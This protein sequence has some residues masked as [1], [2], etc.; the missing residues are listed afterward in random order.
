MLSHLLSFSVFLRASHAPWPIT[1]FLP[2]SR[3]P[4]EKRSLEVK[5]VR[6]LSLRVSPFLR[7]KNRWPTDN[8]AD[9]PVTNN[10]VYIAEWLHLSNAEQKIKKNVEHLRLSDHLDKSPP[11]LLLLLGVYLSAQMWARQQH[12][13]LNKRQQSNLILHR[14]GIITLGI[15]SHI[16]LNRTSDWNL[17]ILEHYFLSET[18]VHNKSV[19]KN[20]FSS[21]LQ[22][23]SEVE[24]LAYSRKNWMAPHS[25]PSYCNGWWP[26]VNWCNAV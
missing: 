10:A 15:Q 11:S 3:I 4:R 17:I 19:V 8:L 20:A 1:H 24:S 25:L 21:L 22:T 5:D 23:E 9:W 13:L 12:I 7:D 16:T 2:L 14:F 18:H 6:F 26:S